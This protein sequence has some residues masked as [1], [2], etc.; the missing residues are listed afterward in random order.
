[1]NFWFDLKYAWRLLLKSKGYSLIC[2]SVVALSVGLAVWTYTLAYSQVLKPLP[3]PGSERWYS[4]QIAAD[5]AARPRPS[6]DA[7]TWQELLK[8]NRSADH[9]GAFA[10]QPA[11]LSEGQATTSLR[12]GAISP[13][14]LTAAGVAPLLGRVFE[15]TDGKSEAGAVA[16]LSFGTWQQY[17]AGDPNIVGK[18]ARIDAEPVQI[19]GVM[20]KEFFAA[21]EDF[22]I[23]RP[24]QVPNLASPQESAMTVYPLI[25]LRENQEPAAIANE[26]KLVV[27]DVNGDYPKLFN[28]GRHVALIPASRIFTHGVT[29]II[30]MMSLMAAGVLLLGCLNISMVFLARLLERSREL[31][32]RNALGASRPRLLRQCLLESGLVVLAGLVGGYVLAFLGVEWTHT[33]NRFGQRILADGASGNLP[34]MRPVDIV[35]AVIFAT[36]IWLLSTLIPA[37]RVTRQDAAVV[38]AGSGKGANVRGSNR[39]VGLLVGLQVVVSCIV[40][41]TCGNVV[42]GIHKEVSKPAGLNT[43]QVMLSTYPTVFD[44]RFSETSQRQRYWENLAAAIRSKVPGSE[45]AFTTAAP[46]RPARVAASIETRQGDDKQGALTLPLTVVSENYFHLLDIRLRSGRLFDSTDNSESLKVAVIDEQMAA[47]YWPDQNVL[48]KRIQL[49]ATKNRDWLTIIGV[50]SNVAG[51]PY[52]QDANLGTIY[53]PLRQAVPSAFQVL[54]KLPQTATDSRVALRA[55][56]FA[57]DRDLPLHN[58]QM[59]DD[60]LAAVNLSYPAMVRVFIVIALITATLAASGLFGLISRSVAQ[61]T[62][63]VGIRRALGATAW[64]A[65]SMFLRQGALYLTVAFI[66]LGLGVMVLPLFSRAFPNILDHVIPVTLGVVLLMAAVISTASYWPTRR[67]VA[68]EP[69][70]ALRY[71]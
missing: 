29:P 15:E 2:A 51:V 21:F 59:F 34:V 57:V 31:A 44:A 68:L 30:T 1:M 28:S 24:L 23:L 46:T 62:Q 16:I 14:L 48:G 64:R 12:G 45:V 33:I 60:Y 69:G 66:G 70:D 39:T 19:I 61:R 36:T 50:V 26:M 25:V 56:A 49:N 20:P 47:R 63:E 9:L 7:Y 58:L 22:E 67:A 65:T 52:R 40:L 4:V 27:D 55:A 6:I 42:L 71:E 41:V 18:T 37:W 32:L 17:F 38:L 13:R 35:T 53:Q 3:F 5:A 8:R 10:R 11:V 54:V 43:A